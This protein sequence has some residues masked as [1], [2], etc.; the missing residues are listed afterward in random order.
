MQVDKLVPHIGQSHP[1][2]LL[3]CHGSLA[4]A[5]PPIQLGP[6]TCLL[7]V[8]HLLSFLY[9]VL[10]PGANEARLVDAPLFLPQRLA[11]SG[12]P[13]LTYC[14]SCIVRRR[15]NPAGQNVHPDKCLAR[16][17]GVHT[18]PNRDSKRKVSFVASQ[19]YTFS[20]WSALWGFANAITAPKRYGIKK[21][22]SFGSLSFARV[23]IR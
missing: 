20:L 7:T 22:T 9:A 3:P 15:G 14:F 17:L 13:H 23:R 16:R 18:I 21:A 6:P 5:F 10:D 4:S 12:N 8:V 19:L 2:P 1:T 11:H